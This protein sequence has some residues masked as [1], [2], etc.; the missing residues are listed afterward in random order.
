MMRFNES[1]VEEAALA[2]LEGL[3]WASRNGL[4]IAPGEPAAERSDYAQVVLTAR[5]RDALILLNPLL[6]SEAVDDAFRRLTRPE[7]AE[8][9]A[10]N[11]AV[12]RLLVEGVTVE[13]RA[14]DGAIRGA[15][16]RVLDFDDPQNN[17][18]L[19]VNQFT[20]TENK[21]NRRPDVVPFVNGL[22]LIVI[23]L[24]NAA[25]EDATIWNAF[26]QLQT[27]K[28]ELPSL[29]AFNEVLLVSDGVE[30]RVGTLTAGR[31]WMKPW[32]T[33]SGET[34]ANP[35]L[36]ELQ[37]SIEGL[38]EKQRFLDLVRDFIVF[39]DAGGG[40]LAKK[41]AGYHQFHAV[42]VAVQETL[43]AAGVTGRAK[44]PDPPGVYASHAQRRARS[45]DRRVGVV[46][47]TQ[48]SG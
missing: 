6:P 3:G 42:R 17:N 16:A 5:L 4:E 40:A 8:L 1:E 44:E 15:Q 41:M 22:P 27:Y 34:L 13:Y 11:R 12:H 25:D 29:L 37:V 18:W 14:P 36:P 35:H 21:H 32:R 26:Q 9:F 19:A 23:E 20:V 38:F 47:H 30:A 7:G 31:E 45:G 10:R 2:W 48:G 46:W 24:K 43:R 28:S 39:E 33:I